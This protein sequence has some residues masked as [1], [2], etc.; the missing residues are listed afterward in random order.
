LVRIWN[1]VLLTIPSTIDCIAY[2]CL[3]AL[4]TM[5]RTTGMSTGSRP[6]PSA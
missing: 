4:R 2:F 6:R 5:P 1:G 3:A